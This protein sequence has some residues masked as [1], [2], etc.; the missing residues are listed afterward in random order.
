MI[1]VKKKMNRFSFFSKGKRLWAAGLSYK[2]PSMC[3]PVEESL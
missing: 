1:C 3:V 2:G